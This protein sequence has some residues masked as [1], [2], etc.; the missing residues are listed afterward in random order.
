MRARSP[1]ALTLA[2]AALAA[3]CDSGP[4]GPG[5]LSASVV[6]PQALGAVLLE[7]TGG[8]VEGFEAQGDTRVFDAEVTSGGPS[9]PVRRVILVSPA[10]GD[11]RFGIRVADRQAPR[12]TVTAL[13][14]A[15]PANEALA[16]SGLQIRIED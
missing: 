10:G 2:C 8:T 3:A 14:A 9:G 4:K 12:P 1:V 15:T 6:S 16:A 5:T 7:F 11:L 13:S